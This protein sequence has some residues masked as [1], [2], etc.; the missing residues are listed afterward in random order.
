MVG[1]ID[2]S[3]AILTFANLSEADLFRVDLSEAE[4]HDFTRRPDGFGPIVAGAKKV[5]FET[6]ADQSGLV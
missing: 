6:D 3:G 1:G 5:K 4:Y 2:P